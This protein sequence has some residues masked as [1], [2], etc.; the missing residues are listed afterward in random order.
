M[1]HSP[2]LKDVFQSKMHSVYVMRLGIPVPR[3]FGALRMIS[4]VSK[5]T[6]LLV[7]EDVK[8]ENLATTQGDKWKIYDDELHCVTKSV[9]PF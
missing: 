8:Q 4:L 1:S 7:G 9:N 6:G 5:E 2:S 3:L